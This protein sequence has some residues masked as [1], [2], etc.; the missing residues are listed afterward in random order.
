[1]I[2]KKDKINDFD[3]PKDYFEEMLEIL[4]EGLKGIETDL[5]DEVIYTVINNIIEFKFEKDEG[6]NML[7]KEFLLELVQEAIEEKNHVLDFWYNHDEL[8]KEVTGRTLKR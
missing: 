3:I 2:L 8:Y 1:M 4:E 7:Y 6:Y 5:N